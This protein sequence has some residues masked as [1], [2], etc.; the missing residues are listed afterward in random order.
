M[1]ELFAND[2][3]ESKGLSDRLFMK[4]RN[5]WD[6]FPEF[7][8]ESVFEMSE[9][10]KHFLDSGKTE[11]EC[12]AQAVRL[13]EERGY[14]SMD[15]VSVLGKGD[16][17]YKK[18]KGKGL[19]AAVIGEQ[20]MEKGLNILGAHLDSP[21][22][23]LKPV[24]IYEE[25]EMVF[26]KT[27]YYGGIKKYQW[28]TIPLA[29]HGVIYNESGEKLELSIGEAQ[30]DPVFTINELLIHLSQEQLNRK[31]SEAVRGEELNVLAG[32]IP[33]GDEDEKKRFKLGFL[34]YLNDV[35]G[36]TERSFVTAE[37]E[38]VPAFK[39]RDVGFDRGMIGSYGQDDRVCAYAALEALMDVE[40]SKKTSVCLFTDKEEVGS[41]GNTGALSRLYEN[42]L[43][44]MMS[45]TEDGFSE[46][47]FRKCLESSSM[48]SSDV[49]SCFDPTYCT[50][51]DKYTTAYAGKGVC[52]LKYSGARGKS[53]ANDANSEFFQKVASVFDEAGVV[54][55]CGELGRVDLGGGGTIAGDLA[56]LGINVIDCGVPV[57]SMHSPF[58]VTS[59]GDFYSAFKGFKE[60]LLNM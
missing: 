45:K 9:R 10:Y 60:F 29:M 7:E 41:N 27:H 26:L 28:S 35:Y 46:L 17:V 15:Q 13:L 53:G 44:E 49:T 12:V 11:R 3:M 59:K 48:L 38:L 32:S 8:R 58:E 20:P 25:G 43:M 2:E 16:K 56:N 5:S 40:M 18:I 22:I 21:R 19:V 54:W 47:S 6:V 23:D 31:A 33:Y 24:P 1:E 34:N 37:I 51:Y 4:S 50:A 57:L 52:L 30:S 55:Q 39:A 36:I 14:V 42:A